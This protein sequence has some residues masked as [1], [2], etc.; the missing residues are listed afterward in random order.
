M[1]VPEFYAQS[2][3]NKHGVYIEVHGKMKLPV[4]DYTFLCFYFDNELCAEYCVD[5]LKSKC[6][7]FTTALSAKRVAWPMI[8][9]REKLQV[10]L[11]SPIGGG[12]RGVHATLNRLF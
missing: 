10:T 11:E 9:S 6:T 7:K 1:P 4:T 8:N 12:H 5:L 3:L 2:K